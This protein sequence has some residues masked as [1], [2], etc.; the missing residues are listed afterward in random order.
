MAARAPGLDAKI[1]VAHEADEVTVSTSE[2]DDALLTGR[3]GDTRRRS[4]TWSRLV[5]PRR[6]PGAHLLVDVNS[7]RAERKDCP[8]ARAA[9]AA[10]AI[11]SG[12]EATTEPL[13][14][15]EPSCTAR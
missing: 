5:N 3:R 4:S 15:E 14:A 10:E 7:Y 12:D 13:S 6:G 8:V 9:L 1:V 2:V 11:A